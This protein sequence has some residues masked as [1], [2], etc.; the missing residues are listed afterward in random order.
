[1][2]RGNEFRYDMI[3]TR[4]KRD[5]HKFRSERGGRR[6][7]FLEGLLIIVSSGFLAHFGIKILGDSLPNWMIILLAVFMGGLMG[8]FSLKSPLKSYHTRKY[9]RYFRKYQE[10]EKQL[11][12]LSDLED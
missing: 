4:E 8:A 12:G 5:Y 11:T 7:T 9:R 6:L 1:M 2:S 10:M 3:L